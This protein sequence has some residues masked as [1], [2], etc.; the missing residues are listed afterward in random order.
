MI[1]DMIS[2][3]AVLFTDHD[4]VSRR[5]REYLEFLR[6]GERLRIIGILLEN[7]SHELLIAPLA[8]VLLP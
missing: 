5:G 7:L 2:R 8:P 3:S 4:S 6:E 1:V